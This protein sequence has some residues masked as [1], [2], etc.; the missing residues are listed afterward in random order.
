MASSPKAI[1]KPIVLKW[2]RSESGL[3]VEE[4]AHKIQTKP[5]YLKA[6][7]DGKEKP[8]MSQLR[9]LAKAFKRPICYFYL[10]NPVD[11]PSI[12]HDFRRLPEPHDVKNYSPAL[13]HEIRTAYDRR[14]LALDFAK[15]TGHEIPPF[16]N[17]GSVTIDADP[18]QVGKQLRKI[19]GITYSKQHTWREPYVA[20]K[21]WRTHVEALGVLVFQITSVELSQM[22]GFTLPYREFPVIAI[23]RKNSPNGRAFSLLHEFVHLLLNENGICNIDDTLL[24]A[25]QG[26]K[27]EIFCNHVAGAAIVPRSEL[28]MHHI[29]TACGTQAQDWED[30]NIAT[31]SRDFGTSKEVIVRRLL[32]NKLTTKEFYDRKRTEFI[33]RNKQFAQKKRE[34]SGNYSSNIAQETVSNLGSFARIM[35]DSYHSNIINLSEASEYLGVRAEKV[36]DIDKLIR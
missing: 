13:R 25:P 16:D 20:Y 10:P 12:P 3:S 26:Q 24:P 17:I 31:L 11:E 14:S 34:E 32:I 27:I 9:R 21:G 28:L 2:L 5:E 23:N 22:L 6:W 30:S 7:E 1:I 15:E 29:V 4:T 8:S 36:A 18:E 35:L 19:V 33:A